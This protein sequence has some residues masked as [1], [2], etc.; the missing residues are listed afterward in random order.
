MAAAA[1]SS[2]LDRVF[3]KTGVGKNCGS[4]VETVTG[5]G[6]TTVL[7]NGVGI[8]RQGDTVGFHPAAGCSPDLST[9]SMFSSN[10]LANGKGIGRIG[11]EYTQDNIILSGSSNVF[12][13]G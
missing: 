13:G 6:S 8:V 10:V 7:V 12:I 1:R 3:S 4:P 2:G 5:L 11:D 9:L